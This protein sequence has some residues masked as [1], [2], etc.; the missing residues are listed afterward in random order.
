[1]SLRAYARHRGCS[2]AAVSVAKKK[3]RLVECFKDKTG[4]TAHRIQN[5][6]LADEEWEKNTDLSKAPAY[7][8]ARAAGRDIDSGDTEVR[9]LSKAAAEQKHWQAKQARLK[10]EEAARELVPAKDVRLALEN[11][12]HACRTRLLRIPSR[13]RQAMPELTTA[14]LGGL[15]EL[16]REAL[17]GLAAG[18]VAA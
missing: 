14:Q 16:I 12:I 6:A 5:V 2:G 3:S 18:Q 9:D 4:W 7:V 11:E 10:F 17:E 13:A 15:E 8:K 1:M